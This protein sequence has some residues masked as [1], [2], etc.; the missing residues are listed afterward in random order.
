MCALHAHR[1]SIETVC[2]ALTCLLVATMLFEPTVSGDWGLV[3]AELWIV[4]S[5]V[6][7]GLLALSVVIDA[8][9]HLIRLGVGLVMGDDRMR[10]GDTAMTR[11]AT[12]LAFGWL[13][14][15]VLYF[16]VVSLYV[17]VAPVGGVLLAPVFALLLGSVLGALVLLQTVLTRL[18]PDSPVSLIRTP[19]LE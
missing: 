13:G 12:S 7:P 6:V 1:R 2:A 14:G 5:V 8:V 17:L 10:P 18:F 11:I 15:C 9:A 4:G 16:V 19:A 3:S